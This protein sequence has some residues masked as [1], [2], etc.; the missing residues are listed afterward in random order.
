[1][2]IVNPELSNC[3]RRNCFDVRTLETTYRL[4]ADSEAEMDDWVH[5]LQI[6]TTLKP[7]QGLGMSTLCVFACLSVRSARARV[8][9]RVYVHDVI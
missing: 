3:R 9:V 6:Q 8:C 7:V 2:E 4:A 5:Y 1:M